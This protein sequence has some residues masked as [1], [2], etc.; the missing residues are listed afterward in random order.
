MTFAN[1]QYLIL[2][3][4]LP[5]AIAV[6]YWAAQNRSQMLDRIGSPELVRRLTANVNAR[7]RMVAR[8]L[9]IAAL[10]LA[11]LALARPQWGENIQI[12]EREGA[13]II[14]ALDISRSMLAED[15]KP[16][17]LVRAK[18]EIAD[19]M[20]RLQGD[21][22]GLVL[23]SG[24]AFLQFPLTFDYSTARNFIEH[25]NTEMITR[26]GT[27]I[28]AAIGIASLSFNNELISQ[29]VIVIITDGE[30]QDGD[31]VAAARAAA[32]DGILIYTIGVGNAAGEPIPI[33]AADGKL[34]RYVEDRQGSM[35]FSRLDEDTLGAV[36]EAG[37]GKFIRLEGATNAASAF[38]EELAAFQ[39]SEMGSETEAI[40][41]ERFQV[42]AL[43][44]FL[45][46]VAG[47]LIPDR[48]RTGQNTSRG[49]SQ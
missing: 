25:A 13:Q 41:I 16:S 4:A 19:M 14:V 26:Q 31:A 37:G 35:V 9:T 36:A 17:R 42:F 15:V 11:I 1:P 3:V 44:A 8:S 12:V 20:Q 22:I 46:L 45:L 47:E 5:V 32:D 49:R 34:L 33:R 29:R 24:A 10:G 43:A 48:R 38:A 2:L 40:K 39:K 21:E 30:N 28:A 27:N 23:F 18:L 6:V 7:G